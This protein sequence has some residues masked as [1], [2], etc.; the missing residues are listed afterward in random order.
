MPLPKLESP[1]YELTIPSTKKTVSFRPYLVKEEKVLMIAQETGSRNEISRAMRDIAAACITDKVDVNQLTIFDL[2]YI[3]LKL[4]AK[5]VGEIIHLK[6]NCEKCQAENEVEVNIDAVKIVEPPKKKKPSNDIKLTDD[7]GV[8]LQFPTVQDV[9]HLN[10]SGN[11]YEQTLEILKASIKT[12]YDG[13]NA[14]NRID[15]NK[16]EL[17]EFVNSLNRTQIDKIAEYMK[18]IPRIIKEIKYDCS[19]CGQE[20]KHKIEGTESFFG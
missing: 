4:R 18:S 6:F 1:Q 5:S 13:T 8:I 19:S 2:E 20:S 10:L 7:V 3:F 16:G 15:A 11:D 9:I 14:Y 12:I 17:D